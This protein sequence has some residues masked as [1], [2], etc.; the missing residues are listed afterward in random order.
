MFQS[1]LQKNALEKKDLPKPLI[2]KIDIFWRLHE[3]LESIQDSD[4][5]ELIEQ[6]EQLDYEILGDMEEEYEDQLENNDRLEQL[7][8][9]PLVK[10]SINEKVKKKVRTDEVI[11]KELVDMGRT[12]NLTKHELKEMGIKAKLGRHTQIGKY[13]VKRKTNMFYY[14]YDITE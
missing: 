8:K 13:L 14:Y 6:L 4:R 1:F 11:L 10:P 9:S 12:K 5:Q 3:L 7:I 2:D